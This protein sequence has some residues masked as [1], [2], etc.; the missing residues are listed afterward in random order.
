[1]LLRINQTKET[2]VNQNKKM[3][4]VDTFLILAI[5][6]ISLSLFAIACIEVFKRF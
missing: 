2:T 5:Y 4:M 3:T 6:S 1:M